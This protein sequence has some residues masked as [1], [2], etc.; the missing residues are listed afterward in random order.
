MPHPENAVFGWQAF[1]LPG[2][3]DDGIGSSRMGCGTQLLRALRRLRAGRQPSFECWIFF[4]WRRMVS[5]SLIEEL[6]PLAFGGTGKAEGKA[7]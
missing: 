7:R 3:A 2:R 4:V 5:E 1:S 6:L